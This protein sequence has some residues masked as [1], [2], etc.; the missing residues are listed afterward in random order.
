MCEFLAS[1]AVD[2]VYIAVPNDLHAASPRALP[3]RACT[4]SAKSRSPLAAPG[5]TDDRRL[6]AGRGQA[7]D[8]LSP[9]LRGGEPLGNGGRSQRQDRRA[10]VL[11]GHLLAAGDAGQHAHQGRSRRWSAASTWEYL[12]DPRPDTCSRTSRPRRSRW[13]ATKRVATR[14]FAEIDEQ[15]G[16]LL[17]FPGRS[18]G[19]ADV[20]LRRLRSARRSPWSGPRGCCGSARPSTYRTWCW[21]W[22]SVARASSGSSSGAIRSRPSWTS[23]AACIREDRDPEP[24]G[25]EGLAD[26]RV[27]EAIE[28]SARNRAAQRGQPRLPRA[29]ALARPGT[30]RGRRTGEST[31]GQRP[32]AEPTKK[33]LTAIRLPSGPNSSTV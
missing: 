8:R 5:R 33:F 31:T 21:R 12:R 30:A 3:A 24:S 9:A 23:F 27:I 22:R 20:Q 11:L 14:A 13:R 26:L 29:A 25:R 15:V 19:A 2:A 17:R 28:A 1:G 6:R 16:A 32:A 4:C 18:A 10:P 7:D